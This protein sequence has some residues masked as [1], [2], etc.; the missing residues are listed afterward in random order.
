MGSNGT[1]ENG[2]ES[3][4]GAGGNRFDPF[5]ATGG[6]RWLSLGTGRADLQRLGKN[7]SIR[8]FMA[9]SAESQDRFGG[10]RKEG[11][12]CGFRVRLHRRGRPA[13]NGG[14]TGR[15]PVNRAGMYSA[16]LTGLLLVG[17][18]FTTGRTRRTRR[19]LR[20]RRRPPAVTTGT[21]FAAHAARP[22]CPAELIDRLSGS[23]TLNKG[24]TYFRRR[25]PP[26]G[27]SR[28]LSLLRPQRL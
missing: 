26:G 10:K 11:E 2:A 4:L 27:P 14:P 12:A 22:P 15:S 23:F 3:A 1:A 13:V 19:L 17:P 7:L 9:A 18:W 24:P 21:A 25:Q 8:K 28:S 20:T 16:P 6:G 5:L